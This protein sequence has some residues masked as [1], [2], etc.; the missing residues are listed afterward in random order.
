[1]LWG[2][3][4]CASWVKAVARSSSVRP[5]GREAC[6]V[7]IAVGKGSMVVGSTVALTMIMVGSGVSMMVGGGV[8]TTVGTGVSTIVVGRGVSTMAVGR[9]VSTMV[10]SG[11]SLGV[12][13]LVGLLLVG[14][15]MA[16][17]IRVQN[18]MSSV[19]S[20]LLLL[21]W[22]L[23]SPRFSAATDDPNRA[24]ISAARLICIVV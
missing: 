19:S 22:T 10:G 13:R 24:R 16:C 4:L 11:V 17:V 18:S 15:D 14:R 12:G 3:T 1:M 21:V 23:L 7:G 5:Q 8:S 6:G 9:K 20:L 2:V